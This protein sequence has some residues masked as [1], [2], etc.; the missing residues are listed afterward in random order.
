ME[1]GLKKGKRKLKLMTV[2]FT[3]VELLAVIVI[4]AIVLIIAVPGVLAIINQTKEKAYLS[5]LDMIKESARMYSTAQGESLTWVEEDGNSVA[6]VLENDLK[7]NGYLDQKVLDPRNKKEIV[8]F[9]VKLTKDS[10][11]HTS[12]DVILDYYDQHATDV[13]CFTFDESKGMITSYSDTCSRDVVIPAHINGKTVRSV[14]SLLMYGKNMTSVVLPPTLELI[15]E[16][17]FAVNHLTTITIP[18]SVKQIDLAAFNGNQLPD[19]QAYFY[20]LNADGSEDKSYVVSYGGARKD[21]VI[22]D[23]TKVLGMNSFQ[24]NDLTSVV[25]PSTVTTISHAA[26][27]SNQLTSIDIP[28]SV[29]EIGS[30]AFAYNQLVGNQ[31]F[32]YQRNA[33]GTENRSILASYG[34]NQTDIVIPSSVTRLETNCLWG[35]KGSTFVIPSTVKEIGRTIFY[36]AEIQTVIIQGKSSLADFDQIDANPWGVDGIQVTF[37]P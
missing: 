22:P 37:Q 36:T 21:I 8:G 10:K 5:Q 12:Y 16:Y 9:A 33:D 34:G 23:G 18:K 11:N 25:I 28:S 7:A 19:D 13:S 29:T 24:Y 30:V 27:A 14:K 31:A 32:V 6:Y 15:E 35:I 1:D 3:L 26:F 17:A 2:G 4:L 20:K